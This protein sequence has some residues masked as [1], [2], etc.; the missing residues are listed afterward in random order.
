MEII[1]GIEIVDLALWLKKEKALVIADLHVGFEEALNN[2]G[3][4]VPRIAFS[5]LIK[6]LEKILER[7]KP[8]IVVIDGDLKHE[9]GSI[10]EQEWRD[11]LKVIDLISKYGKI[12]LVRGNH[13]TISGPIAKKR[14]VEFVDKFEV[15]DCCITHGDKIIETKKKIVIIGHEHPA[16]GLQRG[17]RKEVVKCFL[18]GRWKRKDLIVMPSLN[19]VTEGTDVLSHKIFSPFLKEDL[20]DF[21]V[22]VVADKV[23][24]FG[25][26]RNLNKISGT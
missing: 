9:F 4:L 6:K 17:L 26:L 14:S 23:Y 25:M 8:K 21:N 22:F 1:K 11:S 10:S 20:S 7:T 15:G 3:V 19:Q 18:K 16:V 2:Q 13:D 5:D 12:V 24:D